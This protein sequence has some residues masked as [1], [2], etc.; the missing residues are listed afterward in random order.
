MIEPK[1]GTPART[2]IPKIDREE[3]LVLSDWTNESPTEVMRTLLR[4]SEWYSLRKGTA[5]SLWGAWRS[6]HLREYLDREK[7][8][9][10][11]MDISDVAYDAFLVNGQARQS[12]AARPGET[13]RL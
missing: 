1:A 7:A 13:V 5:Q 2:D 12:L 10:P 11:A 6:G 8:R 4:G 9:L 3:V